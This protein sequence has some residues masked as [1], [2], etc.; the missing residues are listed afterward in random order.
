MTKEQ[1]LNLKRAVEDPVFY[2]KE[3]LGV[4]EIED[5]QMD[6]MRSVRDNPK[7]AFRSGHGTGKTALASWMANWFFDTRPFCKVIT[8]ASS[9]RQVSKMLW[10]EIHKWRR[11]GDLT[12][13][14]VYPGDWESLGL[15]LKRKNYEEWFASGEASDDHEKMEGFHAESILYVI[16]EGKSVPDKTYEAI[17]GALTTGDTRVLVISTPP[18]EKSGYF[19]D[20]FAGKRI[21]YK[22]FHISGIDSKRVSRQWIED[23]KK[24][25]GEDSVIYKNRVLGEFGDASED[26]LIPLSWVE[27]CVNK[28][29]QLDGDLMGGCDVARF[30]ADKTVIAVRQ[31]QRLVEMESYQGNDTMETAGRL[32]ARLRNDVKS[33]NVDV[34]GVGGGVVDRL[35]EQKANVSGINV[36]EKARNSE[37]FANLRAEVW[38]GL[39]ERF[40]DGDIS[41]PDDEELIAQLS[42]IKYKFNSRGQ[43]LVE[44]KDDMKKRGLSSPDKADALGLA[45][46]LGPSISPVLSYYKELINEQGKSSLQDNQPSFR[47]ADYKRTSEAN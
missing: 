8:T 24:E 28:E 40:K 9:W 18:P 30:G 17:E 11:R 12:K 19:Y 47:I 7:T 46:M 22:K 39:R 3:I 5:Y 42:T 16:D 26:T 1:L 41:I 10:P 29:V 32:L 21:G 6:V 35:K 34:I 15:M 45:F 36:A 43:V 25:W 20:I 37:K 14:G 38:W 13:M 33:F 44:S 2:T 27:A 4:A 23:R 31:G